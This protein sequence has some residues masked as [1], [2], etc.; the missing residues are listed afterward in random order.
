MLRRVT[1]SAISG[2][3]LSLNVFCMRL[4]KSIS[5]KTLNKWDN[6]LSSVHMLMPILMKYTSK[7][8]K[9]GWYHRRQRKT[10]GFSA[11]MMQDRHILPLKNG[12]TVSPLPEMLAQWQALLLRRFH[13]LGI[14]LPWWPGNLMRTP[15]YLSCEPLFYLCSPSA[16][17]I[18]SVP[19]KL[20]HRSEQLM[21]H[22]DVILKLWKNV[23][24]YE[25]YL[26]SNNS[27][28]AFSV[29]C[30][31]LQQ[32]AACFWTSEVEFRERGTTL[33]LSWHRYSCK[34]V[35]VS[36]VVRGVNIPSRA[37]SSCCTIYWN[38][39]V[40]AISTCAT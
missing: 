16:E 28:W 18:S 26:Q 19:V 1:Q 34:S 23:S 39:I 22:Q 30:S 33:Y 25:F 6:P 27:R 8:N 5:A 11:C 3:S 35:I 24:G 32:P 12:C 36:E 29:C 7:E 15:H 4:Q 17:K 2:F 40:I 10:S 37:S 21:S 13:P 20:Q 9:G 14:N 38:F 31:A